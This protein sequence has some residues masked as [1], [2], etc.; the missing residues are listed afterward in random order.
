MRTRTRTESVILGGDEASGSD[1]IDSFDG[2]GIGNGS[3]SE[4]PVLSFG[5]GGAGR[6]REDAVSTTS[7][8]APVDEISECPGGVCPVPWAKTIEAM[9][10][11]EFLSS[12]RNSNF[13]G[14][15]TI[16]EPPVIQED[17][18]NHP[19][20]Y[21]D[22]GIETIEAIEAQ[23]SQ[24]EYEGYLRGNCVKYLW[25]WRHK[26]GVEDLKKCK[27]YLERLILLVDF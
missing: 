26:G 23:L 7:W 19:S 18:V 17:V 24:E 16:E 3:F 13:P 22:G 12:D 10:E 14:E 27:W 4:A 8:F 25:R 5:T 21:T 1:R 11:S 20:H 9:S 2:R 15:N 6:G